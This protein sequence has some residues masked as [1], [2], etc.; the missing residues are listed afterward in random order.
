MSLLAHAERSDDFKADSSSDDHAVAIRPRT[1]SG[2]EKP[3]FKKAP[4]GGLTSAQAAELLRQY[5]PNVLPENVEP[6][7]KKFGKL[8]RLDTS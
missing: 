1:A 7:W 8:V 5:G 6:K 4:H 2:S 3:E